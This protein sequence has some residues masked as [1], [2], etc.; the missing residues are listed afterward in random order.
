MTVINERKKRSVVVVGAG[1][2]GLTAAYRLQQAGWHVTVLEAGYRLG[3]RTQTDCV[4][5]YR[6]DT[7]ASAFTSSYR[8]YIAL[9]KELGIADLI[10][11]A[12]PVV[13]IPRN[14]VIHELDVSKM[15]MSGLSTRLF[16]FTDK[17]RLARLLWDAMAAKFRGQLDYSDMSKAA[18]LDS[19]SAGEYARRSIGESLSRY[20]CDPLIRMMLIDD[21]EKVSKVELFSAVANII[22]AQLYG[23]KG[24][25]R[26]FA[27]T[28]AKN[29]DVQLNTSVQKLK[30]NS[31]EV[32]LVV[33]GRDGERQLSADACV[34][35][36]DLASAAQ[37][38][39]D[40]QSLLRPLHQKVKYTSAITVALGF[41]NKPNSRSLVLTLP[42]CESPEVALIFLDHNKCPDRAPEGRYLINTHW[43]S[44]ASKA[45]FHCSDENLVKR[46]LKV[47][48]AYFPEME[49]SLEMS[50]VA[51]WDKALPL[52][53]PGV[54]RAISA[55]NSSLNPASRLQFAGDFMSAA[56]QNTAVNFGERAAENLNKHSGMFLE[57]C[58]TS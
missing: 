14:G 20:F 24:G 5:G 45:N 43:E 49:G 58:A 39:P 50:H 26:A 52:T 57:T 8:D 15:L 41:T 44:D 34:M 21:A 10:V 37:I 47:V 6:I 51:R 19:E 46:T 2:S 42:S 9:A 31:Q 48:L 16:S 30:V 36:C 55:F 1:L 40:Q 11:A 27:E 35:A 25:V 22:G 13:G 32:L 54:Y 23:L 3:G 53:A 18:I 28:L 38:C 7:G 33:S 12:S 56:G 17:I 4:D 29:L